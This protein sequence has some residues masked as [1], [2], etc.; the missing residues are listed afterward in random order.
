MLAALQPLRGEFDFDIESRDVDANPDWVARYDQLV[1]VLTLD[2]VEI[3]YYFLD[4]A[5][6]R[7]VLSRF[8]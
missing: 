5:K 1:P 6:V 2:G 8:R 7:E 3:C 4:I